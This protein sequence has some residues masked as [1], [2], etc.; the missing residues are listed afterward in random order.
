MKTKLI[1]VMVFLLAPWIAGAQMHTA[2]KSYR[3]SYISTTKTEI[4]I[5]NKYGDITIATTPGDSVIIT[6]YAEAI[7][8]DA[9]EAE[10]Q[11]SEI[12]VKVDASGYYI[13]ASTIFNGNQNDFKTDLKMMTGSVFNSNKSL[14]INYIV[15]VP[16]GRSLQINNAYGNIIMQDYSGILTVNLTAGQFTAGHLSGK[17]TFE[18]IGGKAQFRTAN[19]ISVKADMNEFTADSIG[20]AFFDT[21]GSQIRITESDVMTV[22]SRRDK[23]F[24][25]SVNQISGSGNFS[26]FTIGNLVKDCNLKTFYGNLTLSKIDPAFHS[27]NLITGSSDV[28]I[29]LPQNITPQFQC[30]QK[31]SRTLFPA[32]LNLKT[33]TIDIKAQQFRTYNNVENATSFINLNVSG[34]SVN[35]Y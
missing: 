6:A 29:A 35:V 20:T 27:I 32:R 26:S 23:W 31:K 11:L 8:K 16:E 30:E 13:Q 25:E 17:T 1:I 15:E 19:N 7:D 9:L 34:G 10:E 4:S 33:D 14:K 21:R 3:G 12:E 18:L 28:S 22:D 24:L 2:R 5:N